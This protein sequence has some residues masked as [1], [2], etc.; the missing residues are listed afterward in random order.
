MSGFKNPIDEY[1][2]N[3]SLIAV[4]VALDL[5]ETYY[6]KFERDRIELQVKKFLKQ[7]IKQSEAKKKI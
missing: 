2:Y 6:I 3:T 5:I 7:A 1:A 4:S